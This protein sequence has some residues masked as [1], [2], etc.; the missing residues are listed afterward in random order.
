MNKSVFNFVIFLT[1]ILAGFQMSNLDTNAYRHALKRLDDSNVVIS[2]TDDENTFVYHNKK[3]VLLV[4]SRLRGGQ[5]KNNSRIQMFVPSIGK[6]VSQQELLRGKN[7]RL[8]NETIFL[9]RPG[10]R[11]EDFKSLFGSPFKDIGSG[12]QILCWELEDGRSIQIDTT[13]AASSTSTSTL[14]TCIRL[15]SNNQLGSKILKSFTIVSDKKDLNV[16]RAGNGTTTVK[17][18]GAGAKK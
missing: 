1:P 3:N 16:K 15:C 7:D 12:A 9:I 6:F 14:N 10:L 4:V 18:K 13:R 11:P 2:T 5:E 8:Y 17:E